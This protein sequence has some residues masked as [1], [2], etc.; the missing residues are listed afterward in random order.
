MDVARL[1]TR[2]PAFLVT[3]TTSKHEIHAYTLGVDITG[4]HA[5]LLRHAGPDHRLTR[6]STPPHPRGP[7]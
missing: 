5:Q 1:P 6:F 3:S 2:I 7:A 4:T